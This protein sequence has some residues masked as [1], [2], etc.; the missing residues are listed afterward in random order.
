MKNILI[1]ISSVL[2]ALLFGC[3]DTDV[4][5]ANINYKEYAVIR[6][7]LFADSIFAGVTFTR[8]L[9]LGET[10]DIQKAELKNVLAYLKV[11]GIQVIPLHY[12]SN[13]LYKSLYNFKIQAANTYELY[14]KVNGKSIYASTY[15]PDIPQINNAVFHNNEYVDAY[16]LSKP[17]ECY[18]SIFYIKVSAENYAIHSSDFHSIVEATN[19]NFIE[20]VISR[21]EE[22]PEE[23]R[24]SL[25][26][27]STFVQV[28]S[29]DKA[30]SDYFRTRGN[31]RSVTDSFVQGGDQIAWNVKG[32]HV[33]GL[34]IGINKSQITAVNR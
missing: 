3:E 6:A 32:D 15:V 11:N 1:F 31:N 30:Y 18:G 29:F 27:S 22:I 19:S 28:F 17:N 12:A 5:D 21:T 4:V 13:G 23:F 14:A 25:Y 10:Y 20:T 16:V 26:R 7:E 33:I 2:I 9:P 24:T 34:F 8:T